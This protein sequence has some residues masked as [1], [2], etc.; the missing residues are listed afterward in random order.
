MVLVY[1]VITMGAKTDAVAKKYLLGSDPKPKLVR[2]FSNEKQVTDKTPPT[3]LA[4]AKD[5][6]DVPPEN[7]R[8]FFQALKA[9]NVAAEYPELPSGGHAVNG[10]QGPM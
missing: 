8:M 2:F 7:S 4:H 1:P 10:C 6:R 5:D 9:H 3:F